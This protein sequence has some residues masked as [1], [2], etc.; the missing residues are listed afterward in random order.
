MSRLSFVIIIIGI[1]YGCVPI[2]GNEEV[3]V[4]DVGYGVTVVPAADGATG[5]EPCSPG[6][7]WNNVSDSGSSCQAVSECPIGSGVEAASTAT[8][9][10]GS[11]AVRRRIM[12]S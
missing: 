8:S 10:A 6:T 12:E 1:L 9:G 5:C 4:C 3:S 2:E 7:N 11:S